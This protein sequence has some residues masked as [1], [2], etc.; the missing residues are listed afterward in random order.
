MIN[1][2]AVIAPP[3]HTGSHIRRI[4]YMWQAA[5][6]RRKK[7]EKQKINGSVMQCLVLFFCSLYIF[8]IARTAG[9]AVLV[10]LLFFFCFFHEAHLSQ[11]GNKKYAND[12]K[13]SRNWN[14]FFFLNSSL[15]K[16]VAIS[17]VERLV[18][19]C[20]LIF[21]FARK[22]HSHEFL[23]VTKWKTTRSAN[24]ASIWHNNRHS[25]HW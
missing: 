21:L 14:W 12:A 2:I 23:K 17:G 9:N 5:T 4:V 11:T 8:T 24:K 18:F 15:L 1:F 3:T 20:W 10:N 16:V 13:I 6:E 19:F 22:S 25:D 7:N